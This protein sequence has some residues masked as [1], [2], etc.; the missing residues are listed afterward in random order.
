MIVIWL[1]TDST[2]G[3]LA[4][5][6]FQNN[7]PMKACVSALKS[8]FMKLQKNLPSNSQDTKEEIE[9]T[10]VNFYSY[11]QIYAPNN[12]DIGKLTINFKTHDFKILL[13]IR[14]THITFQRIKTPP[15]AGAHVLLVTSPLPCSQGHRRHAATS[16]IQLPALPTNKR[17][18][19]HF[20]PIQRCTV[21]HFNS[22]E[23]EMHRK[24]GN[25]P[26]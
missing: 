21:L 14:K 10:A 3:V 5:G 15:R 25:R 7:I 9:D 13:Q 16:T 11:C 12:R 18:N 23:L 22:S 19:D 8:V 4:S 26:W 24:I 20:S 6:R 1:D 17:P 2:R